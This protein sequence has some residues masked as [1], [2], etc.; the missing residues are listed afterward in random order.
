MGY[1]K[2]LESQIKSSGKVYSV[3]DKVTLADFL[4]ILLIHKVCIFWR[5]ALNDFPSVKRVYDEL[6]KVDKIKEQLEKEFKLPITAQYGLKF[7]ELTED[8]LKELKDKKLFETSTFVT[9][10]M[11]PEN[12]P[13]FYFGFIKKD[14][15]EIWN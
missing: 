10:Q 2:V 6:L 12:T 8:E 13:E 1:L 9:N 14:G 15:G 7:K 5:S 3:S 4:F 11:D